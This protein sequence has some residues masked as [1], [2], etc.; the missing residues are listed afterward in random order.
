MFQ[1]LGLGVLS[2]VQRVK[3]LA[4]SL[5]Q[6]GFHPW[7][8]NFHMLW[9]WLGRRGRLRKSDSEK[10]LTQGQMARWWL[11][12][13]AYSKKEKEKKKLF[14]VV[15]D[16]SLVLF[17][18]FYIL[19]TTCEMKHKWVT[20]PPQSHTVSGRIYDKNPGVLAL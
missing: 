18:M 1:E 9:A 10:W 4:L 11:W 13:I 20:S 3:Y 14:S 5:W 6:L 15:P 19:I 17:S 16:M 2:V 8:G 7:P 12:Q